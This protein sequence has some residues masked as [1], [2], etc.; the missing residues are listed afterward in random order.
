MISEK[1]VKAINK[2]IAAE[3]WSANLYLSMSYYL[4]KEGYDGFAHWLK[5]Q[6]IEEME[7]S[8]GL[9]DYVIKRGGAV[10]IENIDEV[11]KEWESVAALFK[12]VYEHECKVSAL[13]D[14]LVN[15]AAD[16]RDKASEDFLL[17]YVREQVEE[18]ATAQGIMERVGKADSSA[19]FF[20]DEKMSQRA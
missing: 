12:N 18:E 19:L 7:H 5:K 16:L 20:L 15:V 2:Q 13:I 4:Q 9:G 11:P 14:E 1:L 10:V 6:S 17:T 3:M 8:Y